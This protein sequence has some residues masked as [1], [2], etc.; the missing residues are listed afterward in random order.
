MQGVNNKGNCEWV[1]EGRV[2]GNFTYTYQYFIK[3]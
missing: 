2:K 3:Y 1:G